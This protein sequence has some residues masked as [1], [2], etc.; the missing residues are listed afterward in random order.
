MKKFY[1]TFPSIFIEKFQISFYR[2]ALRMYEF[3]T[4]T[5]QILTRITVCISNIPI[6]LNRFQ[7]DSMFEQ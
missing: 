7:S 1:F 4:H 2:K 5:I 3:C 6:T